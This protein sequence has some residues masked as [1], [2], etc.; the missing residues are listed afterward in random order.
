MAEKKR[1]WFRK[2]KA[3]KKRNQS[4]WDLEK[5]TLKKA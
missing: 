4:W 1:P 2:K 5:T 3:D